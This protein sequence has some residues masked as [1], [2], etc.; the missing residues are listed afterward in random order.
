[1]TGVMST[2]GISTLGQE[3]LD[4]LSQIFCPVG[5]VGMHQS[6]PLQRDKIVQQTDQPLDGPLARPHPF[7]GWVP[8][9]HLE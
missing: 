7:G 8:I 5:G 4:S 2:D 9:I 1:M 6:H 3:M